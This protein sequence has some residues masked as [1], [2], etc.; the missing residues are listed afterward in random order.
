MYGLK[1]FNSGTN[2]ANA[3]T[4]AAMAVRNR[5]SALTKVLLIR[6]DTLESLEV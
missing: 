1:T 3:G 4:T 6:N 5:S 2:A